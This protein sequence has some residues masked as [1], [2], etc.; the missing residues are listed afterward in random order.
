[1]AWMDNYI[2]ASDFDSIRLSVA[3]PEDIL[4]W[5]YGEVTKPETI[6][7]RTQKPERDGLFCERIFGPVKDIN[8]HDS[9]LKGVRSREAAVD[10]DGNLVTKSIVRR[11][12]MGHIKLAAPVAHVW[13]MRGTPS[14]LSLLL[15][16]TVRNIEKVVY[17]AAYLVT[18][19]KDEEIAQTL[20]DLIAQH[21]AATAAIQLRYEEEAK[22]KDA[23]VAKL[24]KAKTKELEELDREFL[25]RKSILESLKKG[26]IIP[27]NDFRNLPEEYEDFIEAEMGAGAIKTM[28]DEINLDEMI[29]KLTEEAE[30]AK[31]QKERKIVKRLKLIEGMKTAGIKPS[32]LV[33]TIIPVIPPD[34][35]PMISLPGGRFATSDLNDLYRRVINRNNRL[36][37]LLD[38]NAPEVIV[39]NEMRMLQEAVDALI[40]NNASHGRS[41]NSQ[42]G[43]RKLKSLSDLLKGKQGRFRQNLLGKRVDY[44]GRS[45]IVVGPNL[46][47]NE[48]GLP[49]QMALELF[50]PFVIS[51]LIANEHATNPRIASRMIEAQESVVWD[52]LDE[53]IKGRYVLLNRAPSLHRLSIQAFQPKLIDG[54]A[55]QLHPLV[56]S[57]FNA[58]YDGDQMAVHLPLSDEAQAEARELMSAGKNLLKPAD[59]A[60]VLAIY[61]DVVLGIYY[62]TYDKPGTDTEKVKAFSSIYEA[63][64]AYDH[65]DIALQTPIRVFAKKE[66]RNT[67]LGRVIFNEILPEDYPFDNSVQTSKQLKKVMA[68]IFDHYGPEMTVKTADALKNLAFE[69]ETIASVST[70]KDDYPTYPEIQ[71]FIAE[72]DSKTALIQDQFNQG[73]VTEEERQKLTIA[74][75]RDIAKRISEFLKAKLADLD[76][77]IAVMTN[78]G[79]RGSVS[80]IKLAS[81]EIGI[82][83]DIN[84][85][86]IELPVKSSYKKGLNTLESFIATRGAR[87]GQ[88]STA[89]RTADSGYLTR[90][91]VDVAQDVFTTEEVAEDPGFTVDKAEIKAAGVEFSAWVSGR[92]TAEVIPG[93]LEANELITPE[94]AAQLEADDNVSAV[95]IQSILTTKAVRGIPQRAYGIDMSTRA[96][97]AANQPVGVI[98]A[99][100]LGEPGTQ[101]TLDTKH[102]SG[103]A[104]SGAIAR[105]LPR[106][107]ELL[108]ARSPKGQAWI[109]TINGTCEVW[110]DGNHYVVQITPIAGKTEKIALEGRRAKVKDG[111]AVKTGDVIASKNKG[112]EPIIAGF[113]GIA[114]LVDDAIVLTANASGPVRIEIPNDAEMLVKS[115]A[116]VEAGDRLTTGSL[117][118]QDQLKYKGAEATARYIM[119]DVLAVYAAQ[120]HEIS[121]KHLEIIVHQMFS[122]VS[123]DNEGD[124]SFV[125]GDVVSLAAVSAENEELIKAGK[126]PAEYTQLLL[127]IT[128]VSIWSDSFLSAASFQDTTRVLINAAING[129]VDKLHGLKEN[130]IIGRKIPVGTGKNPL[131]AEHPAEVQARIDAR[132]AEAEIVKAKEPATE[133]IANI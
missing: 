80:N 38:L 27:E 92:Y 52:A 16:A 129:R 59:G 99:Q 9:K 86:E 3:S 30:H 132:E 93:Y 46:K 49:K 105:G 82:M 124:S 83:V 70:C 51:W 121:S 95:K 63:E 29:A 25:D 111:A 23:D 84:N 88:V 13:F 68:N 122:R 65:G 76:T 102:G 74:N 115:G 85:N 35:R 91:L 57:G 116:T 17:F 22:V 133:D 43:R 24:E 2:S 47:L 98:A 117:N 32:D 118:L 130:V 48:C 39:H 42:N 40:D 60:P 11:E 41:V 72:G 20:T 89:L 104:G 110:E 125:M 58:D 71:D 131:A 94:I 112:M 21:D 45:V 15:E 33:L 54:K 75:W 119:N 101:L 28:L 50:K 109:S 34:L 66:I 79:A 6:N 106:V 19:S 96:L 123:I 73:L 87:Q 127:G 62:L 8:P 14:A 120:G 90:R 7:Y 97:V 12:R 56:A 100:S 26:A 128:K 78:S 55:I 37:K 107:E 114:Q 5:S 4:S 81:A 61:Q 31:G 53:V 1:M 67:T 126:Q 44:S 103:V 108:E 64:M 69:Y 77:D 36:K 10:K 113:D 18:N